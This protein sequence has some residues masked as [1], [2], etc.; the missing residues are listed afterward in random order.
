LLHHEPSGA[1]LVRAQTTEAHSWQGRG[2][3][4]EGDRGLRSCRKILTKRR[5]EKKGFL[6]VLPE[7]F[8]HG[9]RE[10]LLFV[11]ERFG[12]LV[13]PERIRLTAF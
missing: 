4:G 6:Y 1:D 9:K 2:L 10:V 7:S 11:G 3:A 8:S 12:A 13:V 5:Q